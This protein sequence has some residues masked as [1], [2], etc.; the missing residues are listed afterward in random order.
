MRVE[1]LVPGMT[2]LPLPLP[3][4]KRKPNPEYDITDELDWNAIQLGGVE[5]LRSKSAEENAC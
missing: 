1:R 5:N 2:R 4:L 3:L